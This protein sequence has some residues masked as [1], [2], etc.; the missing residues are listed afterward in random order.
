MVFVLS[1][2]RSTTLYS[3]L[4]EK[5]L[6]E[7]G[8]CSPH[9]QNS[10][11]A[12]KT[13]NKT[14]AMTVE[15]F[16]EDEF[17]RELPRVLPRLWRFALRLTRHNEDAQDLVQRC[18]VRALERRHQWQSGSSLV[19]WLFAVM[20]SIWMNELRSAQRRREGNLA[21]EDDFEQ[22]ADT[23]ASANPEYLLMYKQVVA[24]VQALPEAQRVVMMLVAVEG[25]SYREAAD[26]L[27]VP[28][29][30]VM[31]R[32]ARGRLTV[33]EQFLQGGVSIPSPYIQVGSQS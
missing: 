16:M 11:S 7:F 4:L 32:L 26:V 6:K 18:Y 1:K 3:G 14:H 10:G 23:S 2:Q 15:P 25:L 8:F 30:T 28:I 21:G 27:D 24:A 29:G 19:N 5:K 17:T 9:N 20:H 22:I 13:W 31:S 12:Q 33:G